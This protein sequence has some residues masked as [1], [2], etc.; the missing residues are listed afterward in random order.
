M[1]VRL[2]PGHRLVSLAEAPELWRPMTSFT[3]AMWPEI[4]L[5]DAVVDEH[6]HLLADAWP[7]FQLVLFDERGEIA[8][9]AESAPL[10]WDGTD[11]GLPA[12]WDDQLERSAAD[13]ASGGVPNTLGALQIAVG[14]AR[15]GSGLSAILLD[16]MRD[17][18]RSAGF[19]A[20]IAC[21]RPTEKTR[22]PLMPIETYAAWCRPDGLPFDPWLRV[23]VRAGGRIVRPS[24]ESMTIAGSVAELR[25]WTGLEFPVSGPYAVEGALRPVDVDLEADRA[26]YLDPNVWVVHRP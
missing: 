8:G 25:E 10:W 6:W 16:A 13:H 9:A 7:S 18:A 1:T 3:S 23:H 26:T 5:H 17:L 11:D 4:M 19:G 20:L 15:R 14:R 22:Y 2:P 24:P 12:G 21:V